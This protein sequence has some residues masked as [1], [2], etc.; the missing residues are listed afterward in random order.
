MATTCADLCA[1]LPRNCPP[2]SL[3]TAHRAASTSPALFL[4]V[5]HCVLMNTARVAARAVLAAAFQT[6][7]LRVRVRVAVLLYLNSDTFHGEPGAFLAEEVRMARHHA[8]PILMVRTPRHAP[9][10]L[11]PLVALALSAL[12]LGT[13]LSALSVPIESHAASSFSQ[14]D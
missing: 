5:V 12:A 10:T 13:A 1:A 7:F 14:R 9:R 11:T 6:V 3:E 8:L 4:G 2:R